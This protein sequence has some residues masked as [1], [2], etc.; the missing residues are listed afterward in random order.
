MISRMHPIANWVRV[1]PHEHRQALNRVIDFRDRS[2][3][4]MAS[5]L[6]EAAV[7]WFWEEEL[8]RLITRP[9]VR[10]QA[11]EHL[12]QQR[13]EAAAIATQLAT[14]APDLVARLE[15]LQAEVARLEG[16]LQ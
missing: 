3:D 11:E 12:Q 14:Q 8:P 15:A 2:A 5:G 1:A 13:H 16:A 10:R 6:P 7:T 4:P 9:E